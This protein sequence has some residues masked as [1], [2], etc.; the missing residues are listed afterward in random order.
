MVNNN[1]NI[2]NMDSFVQVMGIQSRPE[3]T[4][5]SKYK[6]WVTYM[7]ENSGTSF[8]GK[9]L[10]A[11]LKDNKDVKLFDFTDTITVFGGNA[12]NRAMLSIN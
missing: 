1:T 6:V 11:N 10:Y 7:K 4:D 2:Y 8:V 9:V 12:I 3:N 5:A